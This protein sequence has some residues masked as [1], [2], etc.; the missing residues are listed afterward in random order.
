MPAGC[1]RQ[2]RSP[3]MAGGSHASLCGLVRNHGCRLV[4]IHPN[5]ALVAFD[6][7]PCV[8]FHEVVHT[9]KSFMRHVTRCDQKSIAKLLPR[10]Y[11]IDIPR[12]SGRSADE[13]G[14]FLT[15]LDCKLADVSIPH[16]RVFVRCF[17]SAQWMTWT[18]KPG[19]APGS[20]RRRRLQ[21]RPK[22]PR[23]QRRLRRKR[24]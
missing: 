20:A 8:L 2:F 12:L 15:P 9:N 16:A 18:A 17:V 4:F 6:A 23:T 3:S 7:P 21:R 10:M 1:V 14:A 13:E 11:G 24:H 22:L 19:T 5:S